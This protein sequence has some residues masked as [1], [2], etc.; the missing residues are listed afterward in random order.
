[1]RSDLVSMETRATIALFCCGAVPLA[2]VEGRGYDIIVLSRN[3][4]LHVLTF[5]SSSPF[6]AGVGLFLLLFVSLLFGK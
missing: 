6:G 2:E 1:M 4:Q 5:R 3:G